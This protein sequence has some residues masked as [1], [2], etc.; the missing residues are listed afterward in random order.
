MFDF[1]AR[2]V[3]EATLG[4]LLPI[5]SLSGIVADYSYGHCSRLFAEELYVGLW[6]G[7]T[8]LLGR[9]LCA[10]KKNVL[11]EPHGF[12]RVYQAQCSQWW[13]LCRCFGWVRKRTR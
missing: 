4:S 7:M 13:P 1:A 8:D 12:G 10:L 11:K 6:E 3:V 2:A 9:E 5:K